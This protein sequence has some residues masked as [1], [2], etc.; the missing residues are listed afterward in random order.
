MKIKFCS[1]SIPSLKKLGQ[2][3]EV[4][5]NPAYFFIKKWYELHGKNTD[6]IWL[7][8]GIAI[9]DPLDVVVKNIVREQ[10]DILGLGVYVWNSEFQYQLAK[11]VKQQLPDTII[12]LGGPQ[13]DVHKHFENNNQTDFFRKYPYI[14]YVVYG[15]GE[16]AFQ[17]IID[18]QSR[19]INKE[20]FVNIIENIQGQGKCYP[21]E[22]LVDD[23]YMSQSP[24]ISQEDD[25]IKIRNYL[26]SQ[27]IPFKN[28]HWAVEFARG[29][30]YSCTFCDW[31]QN[32][33]KKVKRRKHDWKQDIDLFCRLDVPIRETDANFGQWSDDIKAFDYA[34]SLYDPT[35]T[36]SFVANNTPKLKKDI[37]EYLLTQN[38]LVYKVPPKISIQDPMQD[39]LTAI[40]RPSVPWEDIIKLANNLKEKLPPDVFSKTKMETILGLPEQTI[41]SIIE[42]YV[43]FYE[44]GITQALYHQWTILPN[45]PAADIG[46]QKLWGIKTKCIYEFTDSLEINIKS[47]DDLYYQLSQN[48]QLQAKHMNFFKTNIVVGHKKMTIVDMWAIKIL[49]KKWKML[50]K[51][52]NIKNQSLERIKNMLIKLKNDSMKEALYQYSLH[53]EFIDRYDFVVWGKYD[54]VENKLYKFS[55]V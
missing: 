45:S 21:Y 1:H 18:Y 29:C 42:S 9:L 41:D 14:D 4:S 16:K 54:P 30:M 55:S 28:Q 13:L 31:S 43:K 5:V 36:F 20:N 15:D 3:S 32:L 47:L 22:T 35:R 50:H 49:S 52:L 44:I 24:F 23:L 33:T 6:L 37:T 26:T 48:E 7:D 25:M 10:P 12:V 53:K 17:Q 39:V 40:N 38:A 51:Q 2:D 8:P 46:Y 27:G 11:K 34:I 19:L